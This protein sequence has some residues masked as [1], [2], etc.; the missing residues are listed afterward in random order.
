MKTGSDYELL[1]ALVKAA[2]PNAK[3]GLTIPQIQAL[4]TPF[5]VKVLTLGQ[6]YSHVRLMPFRLLAGDK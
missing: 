3:G 5:G 2:S 4:A 6:F 1:L